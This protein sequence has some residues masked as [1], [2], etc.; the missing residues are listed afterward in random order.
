VQTAT[1][2]ALLEDGVQKRK[3]RGIFAT[4]TTHFVKHVLLCRSM[5]M[6]CAFGLLA[7]GM[8]PSFVAVA[9]QHI[10]LH[11]CLGLVSYGLPA[12]S[13]ERDTPVGMHLEEL[14]RR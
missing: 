5:A 8:F 3:V 2:T 7:I 13:V 12:G 6:L 9:V 11:H 1:R 10:K 14:E 4:A